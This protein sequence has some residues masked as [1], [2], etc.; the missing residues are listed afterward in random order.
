MYEQIIQYRSDSP[1]YASGDDLPPATHGKV[2][3][4]SDMHLHKEYEFLYIPSGKLKCITSDGEYV[5]EGGDVL[6]VNSYVPHSTYSEADDT[7]TTLIQFNSPFVSDSSL[8]Y[9]TR[10][11]KFCDTPAYVFKSGKPETQ[12]VLNCM[13]VI[14][15]EHK[16]HSSFWR[17]YVN[18]N[19]FMLIAIL[20][21]YGILSDFATGK[22][23][24]IKKIIP[25]IE[26]INNN[27]SHPITTADLASILRFNESYFCRLFKNTI[28]TTATEYL[29]FVRVCKAEKLLKNGAS[30]S[31]A[32]YQ[33]G[34]SSLSYF[35]R[36]FKKYK[37]YTPSE[38]RKIIK[39]QEFDYS[40]ENAI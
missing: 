16:N 20:R 15:N 33:T 37:H 1:V 22:K 24:E 14:V 26:Y 32:S 25:A 40:T 36:T 11:L 38:F 30:I 28:G 7:F 29:N 17:D 12:E 4:I 13:N 3:L 5:L 8:H 23:E 39:L 18:A 6:F 27:F 35:N 31:D 2:G 9:I 21:R 19:I 34:F 10:F